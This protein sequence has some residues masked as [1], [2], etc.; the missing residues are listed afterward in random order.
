AGAAAKEAHVR[1]RLDRLAARN[2]EIG[3]VRGRGLMLGI[4]LVDPD[5]AP[6]H[7]TTLQGHPNLSL[8]LI[9]K[10]DPTTHQ[11]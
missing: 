9:H 3:D 8:S 5:A 7:L 2:P 4:E 1:A 10:S 6:A 11:V